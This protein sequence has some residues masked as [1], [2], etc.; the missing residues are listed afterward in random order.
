MSAQTWLDALVL[1]I[2]MAWMGCTYLVLSFLPAT[3][4]SNWWE[5]G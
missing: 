3:L 2:I 5:E 1:A 4:P